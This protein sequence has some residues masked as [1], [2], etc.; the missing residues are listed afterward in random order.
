GRCSSPSTGSAT[1]QPAAWNQVPSKT[2]GRTPAGDTEP[3]ALASQGMGSGA[4][5]SGAGMSTSPIMPAGGVGG[6][7][8]SRFEP[9]PAVG[10][11]SGRPVDPPRGTGGKGVE[12]ASTPGMSTS[13]PVDPMKGRTPATVDGTSNYRGDMQMPTPV[14]NLNKMP[15]GPAGQNVTI[16]ELKP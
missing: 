15:A 2:L 12:R 4:G 3:K 1:Q 5:G 11:R 7:G 14:V 16:P 9:A 8:S 13:V 6:T 10:V